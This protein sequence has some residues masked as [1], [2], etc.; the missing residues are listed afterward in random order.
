M[1]LKVLVVGGIVLDTIIAYEE[2]QTMVH[3]KPE[4]EEAYLLLEEGYKIEVSDQ[5]IFSG[6]PL[7]RPG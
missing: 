3:Q 7:Q 1:A 4:G 2:M 6:Y 5:Q